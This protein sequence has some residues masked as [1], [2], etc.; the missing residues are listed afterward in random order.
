MAKLVCDY[1]RYLMPQKTRN[2]FISTTVYQSNSNTDK[3]LD[4]TSV[5]DSHV[6]DCFMI[7]T[8]CWYGHAVHALVFITISLFHIIAVVLASSI[9]WSYKHV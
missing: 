7:G 8:I 3:V 9:P 1:A 2:D 5:A 6:L 4:K